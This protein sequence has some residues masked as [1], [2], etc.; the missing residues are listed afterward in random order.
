MSKRGRDVWDMELGSL[1]TARLLM[2]LAQQHQQHQHQRA[3]AGAAQA[4]G[5]G[6]VFECKTS[7]AGLGAAAGQGVHKALAMLDCSL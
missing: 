7:A 1:D 2:L 6:R 4:M 3:V 5:G